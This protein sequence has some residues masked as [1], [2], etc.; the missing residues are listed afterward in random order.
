M[1]IHGYIIPVDIL[2]LVKKL[3]RPT[4]NENFE[5]HFFTRLIKSLL[6]N[7][8]ISEDGDSP[9]ILAIQIPDGDADAFIYLFD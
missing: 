2:T 3:R 8:Q 6:Q 1:D 7:R 5:D 4:S 9:E